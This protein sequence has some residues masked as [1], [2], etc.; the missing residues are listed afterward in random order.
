MTKES[1]GNKENG[2]ERFGLT[3]EGGVLLGETR[4]DKET[5]SE[6]GLDEFTLEKK[7]GHG[8]RGE[9]FLARNST[10]DTEFVVRL[11]ANAQSD[12]TKQRREAQKNS[13]VV[14]PVMA[15]VHSFRCSRVKQKNESQG[16]ETDENTSQGVETEEIICCSIMDYVEG[17]QA[18]DW[19][20]A[21]NQNNTVD[22]NQ[23]D[24]LKT[25]P[26]PDSQRAQLNQRLCVA[27]GYM[28]AM[29]QLHAKHLIHGDPHLGNVY[30]LERE[31][32]R[33]QLEWSPLDERLG[34]SESLGYRLRPVFVRIIDSGTSY[35]TEEG[36][37]PQDYPLVSVELECQKMR[38]SVL[39]LLKPMPSYNLIKKII[40]HLDLSG[41][42]NRTIDEDQLWRLLREY[43][44]SLMALLCL[45]HDV[46]MRLFYQEGQVECSKAG[47]YDVDCLRDY[48]LSNA[49]F[50]NSGLSEKGSQG[51]QS[52]GVKAFL[53]SLPVCI[54]YSAE[55]LFPQYTDRV[56]ETLEERSREIYLWVTEV[57]G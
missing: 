32:A 46:N 44:L 1:A 34:V 22:T 28:Q 9:A 49:P 16:L 35:I 25:F 2:A 31:Q 37:R 17:V 54:G 4:L 8:K 18:E 33:E 11:V 57:V 45:V 41:L 13:R 47:K 3:P 14:G 30:L 5:L 40:P 51:K 50:L 43:D 36:N 24:R 21:Y 26:L 12:L 7:L 27:L 20:E 19:L 15:R 29:N 53:D 6:L 23:N 48:V 55:K 38:K 42:S 56:V 10:L 52:S 39:K